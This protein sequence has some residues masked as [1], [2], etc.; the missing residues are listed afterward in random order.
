MSTTSYS[1]STRPST[2]VVMSCLCSQYLGDGPATLVVMV[3]GD[4]L[5]R[6]PPGGPCQDMVGSVPNRQ[7]QTPQ[8]PANFLDA[9]RDPR[10]RPALNA[11]RLCPG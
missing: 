8:E 9:S 11:A 6:A 10:P 4:S 1:S 2:T 7:D 3:S 5:M